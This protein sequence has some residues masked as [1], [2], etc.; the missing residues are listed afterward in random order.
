MRTPGVRDRQYWYPEG[1]PQMRSRLLFNPFRVC[2]MT[3]TT[4]GGTLA[5]T[6]GFG[7]EPLQG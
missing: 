5:R 1:V 2:I 3:V 4:A 7:I 6:P